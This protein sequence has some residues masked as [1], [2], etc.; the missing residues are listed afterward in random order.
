MIKCCTG[1][2]FEAPIGKT[3][4]VDV[5]TPRAIKSAEST[6]FRVVTDVSVDDFVSIKFLLSP[7]IFAF[8]AAWRFKKKRI[9]T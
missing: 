4:I 8:P 3:R 1:A 9:L 7:I 2:H 6:S 5:V